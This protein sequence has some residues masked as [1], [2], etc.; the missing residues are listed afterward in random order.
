MPAQT[1]N[2]AGSG[3]ARW[4]ASSCL[5]TE[6]EF[7]QETKDSFAESARE[8]RLAAFS[9]ATGPVRAA[10]QKDIP[11]AT[12]FLDSSRVTVSTSQLPLPS[13]S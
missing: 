2:G 7:E 1:V 5:E 4:I 11:I 3:R 10:L 13:P 9:A 8:W 6:T 12:F